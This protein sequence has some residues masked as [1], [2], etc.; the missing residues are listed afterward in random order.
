MVHVAPAISPFSEI[1]PDQGKQPCFVLKPKVT[2]LLKV[3]NYN[4]CEFVPSAG[5]V[6]LL[7]TPSLQFAPS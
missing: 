1:N 5:G 4:L 6:F 2:W 3:Q 7:E